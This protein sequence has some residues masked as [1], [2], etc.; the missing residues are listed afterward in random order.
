MLPKYKFV[1]LRASPQ[2]SSRFLTQN[3]M[4]RNLLVQFPP[5]S[6]H[7]SYLTNYK[8][9][10]HPLLEIYIDSFNKSCQTL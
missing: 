4:R 5:F 3:K 9:K 8:F 10:C 7:P 6:H 1:I 2:N